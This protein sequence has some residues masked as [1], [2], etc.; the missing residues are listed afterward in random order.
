M[1]SMKMTMTSIKMMTTTL[2]EMMTMMSMRTM[3]T[4]TAHLQLESGILL[5]EARQLHVPLVHVRRTF[6]DGGRQSIVRVAEVV[7]LRLPLLGIRGA[8]GWK[9]PSPP[10]PSISSIKR[11]TT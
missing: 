11:V 1:I 10:S 3:I 5:L 7:E 8:D 9:S 4:I 6:L 2:M